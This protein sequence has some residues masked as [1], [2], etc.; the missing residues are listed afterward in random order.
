MRVQRLTVVVLR[1]LLVEVDVQQWRGERPELNEHDE[2]CRRQP[3]Q[4]V[5]IVVNPR[6]DGV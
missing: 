5:A 2:R 1:L 6:S 4:H 3:P